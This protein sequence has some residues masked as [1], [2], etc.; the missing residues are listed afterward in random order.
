VYSPDTLCVAVARLGRE[1]QKIVCATLAELADGCN[2]LDMGP[3]LHSLVLV[4]ETH[5]VEAEILEE[6]FRWKPQAD[7]AAAVTAAAAAVAAATGAS[8]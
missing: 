1:D 7:G 2:G 8:S 4:G 3:P 5:P 6:M